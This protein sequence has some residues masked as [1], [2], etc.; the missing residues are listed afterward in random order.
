VYIKCFA[1]LCGSRHGKSPKCHFF[2]APK[3]HILLNQW[4]RAIPRK[5]QT[6]S[7]KDYLCDKHFLPEDIIRFE[8]VVVN[9]EVNNLPRRP[10]LKESA[11]PCIW[12][13]K[14]H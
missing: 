12:P 14:Y 1:P 7:E 9:G 13:S 5:D 6:L 10:I 8:T 11:I 2:L 4:R 3:N